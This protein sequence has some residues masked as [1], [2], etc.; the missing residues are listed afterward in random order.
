MSFIAK[1]G[2]KNC[3]LSKE[4]KAA[5]KNVNVSEVLFNILRHVFPGNGVYTPDTP[6]YKALVGVLKRA[7][8]VLE[9]IRFDRNKFVQG[10]GTLE[11]TAIPFLYNNRTGDDDAITFEF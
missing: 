10:M 5:L 8:K 6:E 7:D 11:E 2:G 4:E 3:G 1:I 9:L